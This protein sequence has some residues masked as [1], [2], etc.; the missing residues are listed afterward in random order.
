LEKI[1]ILSFPHLYTNCNDSYTKLKLK[2][3]NFHMA[4]GYQDVFCSKDGWYL[5]TKLH[6]ITVLKALNALAYISHYRRTED[7]KLIS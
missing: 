5:P 7:K 2:K 3:S 4:M 6:G 1:N